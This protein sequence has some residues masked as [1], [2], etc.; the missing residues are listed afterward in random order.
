MQNHNQILGKKGEDI[1][2]KF[3]EKHGYKIIFKNYKC[4]FGE[5]DLIAKKNNAYIFI[6]VKTRINPYFPTEFAINK[7][8]Q[9][10][11]KNTALH[12]L[13]E[14]NIENVDI[15]FDVIIIE[16]GHIN[17]IQNAFMEN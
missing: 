13:Q 3:L 10:H 8:K 16:N 9:V 15:Q 7:A 11:I 2:S 4:K 5:I 1:S 12:F 6:E 17:F 14:Y